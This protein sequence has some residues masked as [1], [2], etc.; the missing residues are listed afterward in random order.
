MFGGVAPS[1]AAVGLIPLVV[2]GGCWFGGGGSQSACED[3][4][5]EAS[6]DEEGYFCGGGREDKETEVS[7]HL[8]TDCWQD[9]GKVCSSR[10]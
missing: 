2:A 7:G 5:S 8:L 10:Y 6:R 9:K 1:N 4:V 3:G